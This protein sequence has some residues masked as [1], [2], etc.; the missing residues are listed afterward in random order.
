MEAS[1]C[2]YDMGLE[3]PHRADMTA[4][5]RGYGSILTFINAE[6]RLATKQ[7]QTWS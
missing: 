3:M 7:C 1:P 4:G 5:T 6:G 2:F